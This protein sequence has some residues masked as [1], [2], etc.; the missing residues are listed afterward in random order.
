MV[1]LTRF[2]AMKGINQ[3]DYGLDLNF[4]GWR[5]RTTTW[6]IVPYEELVLMPAVNY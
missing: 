5:N 4:S 2:S 6:G 3:L 1:E